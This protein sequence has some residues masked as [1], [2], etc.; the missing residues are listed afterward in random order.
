[1]LAYTEAND[2]DLITNVFPRTFPRGQSVELIHSAKFASIDPGRLTPQ[3]QEHVT[4]VFYNHPDEFRIL[5][6]P[7]ANPDLAE[8]NLAVD[9]IEDLRRLEK[10]LQLNHG[11]PKNKIMETQAPV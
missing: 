6:I 1:M 4:Q 8:M 3:E 10:M 9:T 2:F 7:S 11:D 5:N